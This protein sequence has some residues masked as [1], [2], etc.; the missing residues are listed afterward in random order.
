MFRIF[1]S[2][3]VVSILAGLLQAD[4]YEVNVEVRKAR[5]VEA[6]VLGI[7]DSE[8]IRVC[9]DNRHYGIFLDDT[10][11]TDVFYIR[12]MIYDPKK[13]SGRCS[14]PKYT[15]K[16][17]KLVR[18]KQHVTFTKIS[19]DNIQIPKGY[20]KVLPRSQIKKKTKPKDTMIVCVKC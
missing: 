2:L 3:L 11:L 10:T 4:T 12:P 15:G 8:Q 18:K 1:V 14:C 17:N 6:C 5:Y 20:V 7:P 13:E 19:D 16:S 9:I